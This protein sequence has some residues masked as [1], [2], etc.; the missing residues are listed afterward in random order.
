MAKGG[1][2]MKRLSGEMRRKGG[3]EEWR[4]ET[5]PSEEGATVVCDRL[6]VRLVCGP[7]Y[8]FV[9]P[10]LQG[11]APPCTIKSEWVRFACCARRRES[12]K[13][14]PHEGGCICC[15]SPVCSGRWGPRLLISDIL[16]YIAARRDVHEMCEGKEKE[17]TMPI[18]LSS[19]P[20]EVRELILSFCWL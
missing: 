2:M 18:L 1:M 8:P 15:T 17:S 20:E 19:L 6:G 13:Y 7:S 14:V 12:R 3:E 5:N 16:S 4:V 9:P 11:V 10:F